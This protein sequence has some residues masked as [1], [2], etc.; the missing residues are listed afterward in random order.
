MSVDTNVKGKNLT[1]YRT[2]RSGSSR[3]LVTPVLIGMVSSMRVV[4]A[5]VRGRKLAVEFSPI[6]GDAA[7]CC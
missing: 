4:T 3:I 1:S 2:V 5:G 7:T 6:D